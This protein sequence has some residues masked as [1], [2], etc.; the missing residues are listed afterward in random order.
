[1]KSTSKSHF[2]LINED[3][4]RRF[5]SVSFFSLHSRFV[6]SFDGECVCVC[7]F[8][9]FR[10]IYV[11]SVCMPLSLSLCMCVCIIFRLFCVFLF[12][13][14]RGLFRNP[15]FNKMLC[16]SIQFGSG[17]IKK[18]D[19]R[20]ALELQSCCMCVCIPFTSATAVSFVHFASYF[21][22]SCRTLFYSLCTCVFFPSY[23]YTQI[24][25]GISE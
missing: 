12:Y 11:L 4:I 22:F 10:W 13:I 24:E 6:I 1:M 9:V 23:Y 16:L 25:N 21:Y 5:L 15:L 3:N 20:F 17:R 18:R 2:Y 14:F 7:R 8:H 19:S